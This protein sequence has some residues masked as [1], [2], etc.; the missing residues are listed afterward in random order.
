MKKLFYI[1]SLVVLISCDK[2]PLY[3]NADVFYQY[4]NGEKG[5]YYTYDIN[6]ERVD[7]E[8]C[9]YYGNGKVFKE[10]Q[11]GQRI[12]MK[13]ESHHSKE[14]TLTLYINDNIWKE[15]KSNSD[16]FVNIKIP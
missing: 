15:Y 13:F 9:E 4:S 5:F 16:I 7:N 1:L 6:D 12:V 8:Y 14:R 10:M 3:T 11:S 2:E